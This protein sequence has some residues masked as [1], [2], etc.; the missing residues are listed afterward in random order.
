M[1]DENKLTAEA[2][3]SFGK[4][5]ARKIRAVGKIPAVIYGH[6]TEPQHIT[7]PSHEVSLLLRKANAVLDLDIPVGLKVGLTALRK[8]Y[9]Q[10]GSGRQENAFVRGL[11]PQMRR[12]VEPAL[13]ILISEGFARRPNRGTERVYVRNPEKSNQVYEIISKMASAKYRVV[14]RLCD[15]E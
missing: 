9:M 6:G 7:L 10:G 13:D 3:T 8:L 12:L 4:G 1:A 14:Q 5:A 15:L 2:R 11:R